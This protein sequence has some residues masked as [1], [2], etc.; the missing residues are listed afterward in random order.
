MKAIHILIISAV[1]IL[2][3]CTKSQDNNNVAEILRFDMTENNDGL[4]T[5]IDINYISLNDSSAIIGSVESVQQLDSIIFVSDSQDYKLVAFDQKG[6]YIGQI[7]AKGQGVG[8]YICLSTFFLDKSNNRI[9]I[10][11]EERR[12]VIYYDLHTF[13]FIEEA[14]YPDIVSSSCRKSAGGII[15]FNQEYEGENSDYYFLYTDSEGKITKQYAPKTFKSGY[16]TGASQPLYSINGKVYGYTPY[17]MTVYELNDSSCA[18]YINISVKDFDTPSTEY[19]NSISNNGKSSSLFSNLEKSGYIS[20][21]SI[22]EGES[23][24]LVNIIKSNERFVGIYDKVR[25]NSY[26]L[27]KGKFAEMLKLG[28]ISYFVP[29]SIDGKIVGVLDRFK[30]SELTSE[31][32]IID[33]KLTGLLSGDNENPILVEIGFK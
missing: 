19:L 23:A 15:W 32:A 33:E 18:P 10:W 5:N 26:M 16:Q 21:Y 13:A 1:A 11:D 9:A 7:G 17:D 24:L 31:G 29:N 30:L 4:L 14:S 20:F 6:N 22:F 27:E 12:K 3:S 8:E 25:G 28:A 2:S